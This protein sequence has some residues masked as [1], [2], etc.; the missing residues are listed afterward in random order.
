LLICG[1]RSFAEEVADLAGD[2]ADYRVAGFVENLDRERTRSPLAGLP[3]HW[4]DE[5]PSG[6]WAICAL[7]TTLRNRFTEQLDAQRVPFA[8]LVHPTAHVSPSSSLGI[9]AIAGAGVVVGARTLI[10][11][12]VLLNRGALIGH[13]T[14]IG[15]HSSVLAGANVAGNCRVGGQVFVGMG[16]LVL[17]NLEVGDQ[18]VIAAGSIVTRDVPAGAMVMGAPARVVEGKRGPR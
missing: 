8:T 14:T 7:A 6:H 13:H 18:S 1:T 16:A 4:I 9:G 5:V 2:V 12:H 10:G 11:A 15:D 3:V 17:D